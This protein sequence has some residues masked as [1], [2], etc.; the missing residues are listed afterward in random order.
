[1]ASLNT[2]END[3]VDNANKNSD[4]APVEEDAGTIV[5]MLVVDHKI[6]N[7]DREHLEFKLKVDISTDNYNDNEN[8]Y[9]VVSIHIWKRWTDFYSLGRILKKKFPTAK[10]NSLVKPQR[11]AVTT[12]KFDL[13]YVTIKK[14]AIHQFIQGLFE[15]K[16][17]IASDEFVD[18]ATTASGSNVTT[19]ETEANTLSAISKILGDEPFT[20]LNL[21][22]G[23][24]QK[25]SADIITAGEMCVWEFKSINND[26]GC[27]AQFKPSVGNSS[28]QI[29]MPLSRYASQKKNIQLNWVSTVPGEITI[30]FDNSYSRFR[31]K[32][33]KYRL[34]VI[35]KDMA[36]KAVAEV[37]EE[38]K[39]KA[40]SDGKNNSQ[41]NNE[42]T[43]DDQSADE[44]ESVGEISAKFDKDSN[45]DGSEFSPEGNSV[46]SRNGSITN[47]S[48]RKGSVARRA[49]IKRN[50]LA[51]AKRVIGIGST[52]N[53]VGI[54]DEH[55]HESN[56][57]SDDSSKIVQIG[58]V[59]G[60]GKSKITTFTA[61]D[62]KN[63]RELEALKH[64]VTDFENKYKDADIEIERL[65]QRNRE[66]VSE[67]DE[68]TDMARQ[69]KA[70][71][72]RLESANVILCEESDN[73][74]EKMLAAE[75]RA[76]EAERLHEICLEETE[77]HKNQIKELTEKLVQSIEDGSKKEQE[78][79]D[80][81]T[82]LKDTIK[83]IESEPQKLRETM[84]YERT[85]RLQAEAELVAAKNTASKWKHKVD[86]TMSRLGIMV[87]RLTKVTKQ[88]KI[89]IKAIEKY[90]KAETPV[91]RRNSIENS[92][93]NNVVDNPVYDKEEA[94]GLKKQSSESKT[95]TLG[96]SKEVEPNDVGA[97]DSPKLNPVQPRRLSKTNPFAISIQ[98][99]QTTT[100]QIKQRNVHRA[101]SVGNSSPSKLQNGINR[102]KSNSVGD[103]RRNTPIF[104]DE[105]FQNKDEKIASPESKLRKKRKSLTEQSASLIKSATEQS[106][107][108]LNSMKNVISSSIISA[109]ASK[110]VV[111]KS[112]DWG[113][114]GT[115]EM[116]L[117]IQAEICKRKQE[118]I[119]FVY[120]LWGHILDHKSIEEIKKVHPGGLAIAKVKYDSAMK[121]LDVFL[122][123]MRQQRPD[124]IFAAQW[125]GINDKWS[126]K[127]GYNMWMK[128]MAKQAVGKHHLINVRIS[129]EKNVDY[130]T[131]EQMK[132]QSFSSGRYD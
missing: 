68:A 118:N 91:E 52:D 75:T 29:V 66:L 26:M 20:E 89:L 58:T 126:N 7:T 27:S 108:L 56:R 72:V 121:F 32:I 62:T 31:S 92:V 109:V 43:D 69:R 36:D 102:P 115:P 35:S 76:E 105:I 39:L 10:F 71:I 42:N 114:L 46:K 125:I 81:V 107:Q 2:P 93:L 22:A 59:K 37:E 64:K 6:V 48:N 110:K 86:D 1:M 77:L 4:V 9:E 55:N 14:A 116:S 15:F 65:L 25:I 54:N 16:V 117:L 33:M 101:I 13:R 19:P 104:G 127:N 8:G 23:C 131:D 57:E 94:L 98:A 5:D 50:S 3:S 120:N 18:F 95:N 87:E 129:I 99:Q 79:K 67:L 82:A 97:L 61:K 113:P 49:R 24:V 85:L 40:I 28:T 73:A 84:V 51:P 21:A 38:A 44:S 47:K 103:R 96:D 123:H 11:N 45:E 60:F 130:L 80:E 132:E 83:M 112:I 106:D 88:K 74:T 122:P 30:V 63:A 70:E 128:P 41:N 12:G 17:I 100:D 34:K 78:L 124:M 111:T 90:R 53:S 119:R